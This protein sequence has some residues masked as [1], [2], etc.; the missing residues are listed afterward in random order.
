MPSTANNTANVSTGKGV[1]GGYF[2]LAPVGT[3]LPTDNTTPLD[4]AFLNMGYL[5]DDGV[6][7]SDSST[8]DTYQ[9]MNGDTIDSSTGAPEKTFQVTF[10]EVKKDTLAVLRGEANVTDADGKLT[11]YDRGPNDATYVGV[12]ELL[13]KNGRKWRRVVP[14]C[15][16]GELGDET[17]V[18]NQLVGRQV[19]MTAL[20]DAT[21]NAY[22]V[23]HYDSTETEAA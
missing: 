15:N 10:R 4:A 9:D 12:F 8:T 23:D 5:G 16:V 14:Q 11:A 1:R 3:D 2:F 17:I 18:Y 21:A 6:V 13:L 19:T 22:Y 7:F 20:M